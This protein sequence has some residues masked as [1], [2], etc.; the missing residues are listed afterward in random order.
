MPW[1]FLILP[2]FLCSF[3]WPRCS[4]SPLPLFFFFHIWRRF[5]FLFLL[6][7]LSQLCLYFYQ[8]LNNT[9]YFFIIIIQDCN[10]LILFVF[11]I[12]DFSAVCAFHFVTH[13]FS[14][15]FFLPSPKH[16]LPM[17]LRLLFLPVSPLNHHHVFSSPV[18]SFP[19]KPSSRGGGVA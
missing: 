4:F 13:F 5:I 15:L 19:F 3:P 7:H 8:F 6:S 11:L 10:I 16:T 1:T 9:I 12:I 17:P 14:L 2:P 18:P